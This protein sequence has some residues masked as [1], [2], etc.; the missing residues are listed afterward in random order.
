[1]P[2]YEIH[3]IGSILAEFEDCPTEK[4]IAEYLCKHTVKELLDATEVWVE[5]VVD[6]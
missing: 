3:L 4:Q 5:D 6:A 2:Q 1:M